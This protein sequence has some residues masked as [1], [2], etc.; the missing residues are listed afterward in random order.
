MNAVMFENIAAE[1]AVGQEK[2]ASSG[3]AH[4]SLI[5]SSASLTSHDWLRG[6]ALQFS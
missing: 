6:L 4:H 5:V 2:R 1:S 3:L